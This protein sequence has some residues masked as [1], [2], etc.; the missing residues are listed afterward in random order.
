MCPLRASLSLLRNCIKHNS[1]QVY[2]FNILNPIWIGDPYSSGHM[3]RY[4]ALHGNWNVQTNEDGFIALSKRNDKL[5][6]EKVLLHNTSLT[7]GLLGITQELLTNYI[8]LLHSNT[9]KINGNPILSDKHFIYNPNGYRYNIY[10]QFDIYK[11]RLGM[12][13]AE[14][15]TNYKLTGKII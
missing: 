8:L 9:L 2:S 3:T 5:D 13:F 6:K 7:S 10:G 4:E 11:N 14:R 15:D 1:K 12:I